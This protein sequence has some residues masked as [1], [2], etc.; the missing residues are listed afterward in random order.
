MTRSLLSNMRAMVYG[1]ALGLL[2]SAIVVFA[3]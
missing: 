1:S 3:F 2:L